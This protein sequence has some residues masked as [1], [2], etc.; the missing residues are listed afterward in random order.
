VTCDVCK[1]PHAPYE[2]PGGR[3]VDCWR[4]RS[5]ELE[6]T[7]RALFLDEDDLSEEG[8]AKAEAALKGKQ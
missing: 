7:L 2:V 3:C 8:L 6:V 4:K 1:T 5:E